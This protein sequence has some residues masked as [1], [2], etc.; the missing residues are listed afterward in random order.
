MVAGDWLSAVV[1]GAGVG[2]EKPAEV[3][4]LFGLAVDFV[5]KDLPLQAIKCL[6]AA[7]A[8]KPLPLWEAEARANLG[9]LLLE[10]TRNVGEAKRH[11]ETALRLVED[12]GVG[13]GFVCRV[14][15]AL[16]AALGGLGAR[17]EQRNVLERAAQM[18]EARLSGRE[19]ERERG[20]D[21][22]YV[23]FR[24]RLASLRLE[25]GDAGGALGVASETLE[26]LESGG[27]SGCSPES[28]LQGSVTVLQ[29]QILSGDCRDI[30]ATIQKCAARCMGANHELEISFHLLCA[31][32]K[33]RV[34]SAQEVRACLNQAMHHMKR[35]RHQLGGLESKALGFLTAFYCLLESK[36]LV[37][38]GKFDLARWQVAEARAK[39]ER[40]ESQGGS[41][42]SIG[43]GGLGLLE[44]DCSSESH[45]LYFKFLLLETE[46][47]SALTQSKV[48]DAV[49]KTIEAM[50]LFDANPVALKPC[51]LSV[52]LLIGSLLTLCGQYGGSERHLNRALVQTS[53]LE[54]GYQSNLV[55]LQ[56]CLL[57]LEGCA[58]TDDAAAI[59]E[60]VETFAAVFAAD[61]RGYPAFLLCKVVLAV[62]HQ[63][64]GPAK[65]LVQEALK[66]A[67]AKGDHQVIV[68][69]LIEYAKILRMEGDSSQAAESIDAAKSL[70]ANLHHL[71]S[72]VHALAFAEVHQPSKKRE[73]ILATVLDRWQT[74]VASL[75]QSTIADI[76]RWR[77][78]A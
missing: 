49:V 31:A 34:G 21:R 64:V 47:L 40:L 77:V 20:D 67:H 16:A 32:H 59:F 39:V 11:L 69:C 58:T 5:S 6:E 18:E 51:E 4:A 41:G 50:A 29:L 13:H 57:N 10:F 65:K 36:L 45:L 78:A 35:R 74:K 23:A 38:S 19:R 14:Q 73:A 3:L 8:A 27:G 9:L 46:A 28:L 62:L 61:S 55:K 44:A 1:G 60:T 75:N 26:R 66:C 42:G 71:P 54:D 12:H 63:D 37:L 70:A 72:L 53:E 76:Q 24:G 30:A 33:L 68:F 2:V 22:W 56:L 43:G 15:L 7:L 25:E 52:H 17:N 48:E